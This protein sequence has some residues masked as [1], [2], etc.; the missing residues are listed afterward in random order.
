MGT[1]QHLSIVLMCIS[2]IISEF[3]SL[4]C[5]LVLDASSSA[6]CQFRPLAHF[7]VE[8]AVFSPCFLGVAYVFQIAVPC[9]LKITNIIILPSVTLSMEFVLEPKSLIPTGSF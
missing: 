3:V 7:S 5:S 4:P 1:K 2:L 6:N 8:A 9:C